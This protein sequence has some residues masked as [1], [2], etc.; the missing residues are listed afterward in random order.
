MLTNCKCLSKDE[1]WTYDQTL[2]CWYVER[3]CNSCNYYWEGPDHSKTN[4]RVLP[5]KNTSLPELTAVSSLRDRTGE[6]SIFC[7]DDLGKHGDPI[8]FDETS[9]IYQ[10]CELN[11]NSHTK[12]LVINRGDEICVEVKLGLYEFPPE[13]K[14]FNLQVEE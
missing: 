1:Q 6:Y 14:M 13:W 2:G 5:N 9:D 7:Y 3:N 12:I 8:Q 10:F 4:W 11:K